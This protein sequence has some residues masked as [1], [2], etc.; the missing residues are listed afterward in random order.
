MSR[1]KPGYCKICDFEGA[2]FLNRKHAD[3]PE[4][5]NAK[6][7]LEF[8]KTLDAS[9]TF[10]RQ[11]WY[12]HVEHITHP[13]VTAARAARNSPVVV[14]KTTTGALEAI[15]DIGMKNILDHPEDVT[16]DHALRAASELNKKQSGTDNVLI[17]LAKVLSGESSSE[18]IVGEWRELPAAQED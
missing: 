18:A 1:G 12:S 9:F 6:R 3:D 7:A 10:T 11:T 17:V 14:P 15:R 5:F 13:L 2:T 16:P 4:G 8:A